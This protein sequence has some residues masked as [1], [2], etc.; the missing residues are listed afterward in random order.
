MAPGALL[1]P[2]MSYCSFFLP[3]GYPLAKLTVPALSSS[4]APT[5]THGDLVL[6]YAIPHY[7]NWA[8][9]NLDL[10]LPNTDD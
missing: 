4:P 5:K 10:G 8:D 2:T 7:H 6:G 9:I 1:L 3:V